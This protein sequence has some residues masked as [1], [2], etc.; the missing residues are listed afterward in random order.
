M[1]YPNIAFPQERDQVIM[2]FFLSADLSPNLICSLGQ[3]QVALEAIF[4]LD[5]TAVDGKYVKDFVFASGGRDK[6]STFKFLREQPTRSNWNSW[7]NFW[8][9][10]TTTGDTL[11]VPLGKW[12]SPTHCIWKWYYRADT[13]NLQ[14]VKGNTYFPTSH[15]LAFIHTSNKNIP[16]DAGGTSLAFGYPGDPYFSYPF[17]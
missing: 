6:A 2:E 14:W 8:H 12:I 13:D 11:K 9:N 16:S 5:L 1:A 4:L 3:C 17:F 7:F 10:F 15:L